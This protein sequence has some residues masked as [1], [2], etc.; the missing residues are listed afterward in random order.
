MAF[1]LYCQWTF[2]DETLVIWRLGVVSQKQL[3]I[4]CSVKYSYVG[5]L[6]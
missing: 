1:A 5:L 4:Q 2:E 3:M 6:N